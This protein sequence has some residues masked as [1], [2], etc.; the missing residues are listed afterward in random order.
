MASPLSSN[1]SRP[2]IGSTLSSTEL[3]VA[4]D[5]VPVHH[6]APSQSQMLR[7]EPNDNLNAA[8]DPVPDYRAQS[9]MLRPE[10][11][12]YLNVADGPVPNDPVPDYRPQSQ[13]LRPEPN[14]DLNGAYA[15]NPVPD[16]RAHSQMLRP[17]QNVNLNVVSPQVS[18]S[19]PEPTQADVNMAEASEQGTSV[20]DGTGDS[21]VATN[22]GVV[23]NGP[24]ST[25]LDFDLVWPGSEALCKTLKSAQSANQWQVPMGVLPISR[26]ASSAT[27]GPSS[28][29]FDKGPSIEAIPS[30][31]SHQ[32]VHNVSEMVTVLVGSPI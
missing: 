25:E 22:P 24:L 8:D 31:D 4:D 12:G 6:R 30:G 28:S 11:N 26:R 10:T 15:Y 1:I 19:H 23:Y 32:A 27:F 17:E 3:N 7:P 20:D 16:Y 21:D 13:M 18:A 14:G 9:Q 2:S 5:P 29:S